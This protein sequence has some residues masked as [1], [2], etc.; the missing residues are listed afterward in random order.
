MHKG[1]II[2]LNGVSSSGKSSLSKE[3]VN[4]L[5]NYFHLSIVDFNLVIDKMEDR[6]GNRLI[7]VPI[8]YFFHRT[9]QM[10][11]DK[12]INLVV[13]QILHDTETLRDFKETLQDY[14]MVFVGVHC[15]REELIRREKFRG[16]RQSGL[17]VS[18]LLFVH[19]QHENYDV[20][21]NTSKDSL[22][23]CVDKI[24]KAVQTK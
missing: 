7:P 21:V 10:F 11:S 16:D 22:T 24:L 9:I 12:G 8:E 14:P 17:S 5:P 23:T 6:E 2:V 19:K 4:H 1:N 18:Q 3:L 13:D 15:L 20:V